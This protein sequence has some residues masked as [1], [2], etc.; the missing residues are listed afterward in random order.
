MLSDDEETEVIKII[1]EYFGWKILK[2]EFIDHCLQLFE[3][4]P[5]L[6]CLND[7]Q[8]QS[9]TNRLWRQYANR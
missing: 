1:S 3:D 8:I 5:G 7:E 4:I 6:E 9:I 2:D